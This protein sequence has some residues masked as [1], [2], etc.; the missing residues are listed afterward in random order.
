M[1]LKAT[2]SLFLLQG[3]CQGSFAAMSLSYLRLLMSLVH[4]LLLRCSRS[5]WG[6]SKAESCTQVQICVVIGKAHNA[7]LYVCMYVCMYV[8][9]SECVCLCVCVCVCVCVHTYV[10]TYVCTYEYVCMYVCMYTY[11]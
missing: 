3:S 9:V 10:R 2:S 5:P 6:T 8:C 7:H 11:V 4:M 1:Q